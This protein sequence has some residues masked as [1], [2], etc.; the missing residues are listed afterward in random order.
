MSGPLEAMLDRVTAV[1]G[2]RGALLAARQDGLVV[3]QALMEGVDGDAI[4][5]L[6]ASLFARAGQACAETGQGE[7]SLV[8]CEGADGGL[9]V[10]PLPDG[11]LLLVALVDPAGD[12][13]LARLALLAAGRSGD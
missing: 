12:V 1:Q 7:P 2:V 6:A 4:A 9:L 3:T 8:H 13:G 5:A 10:A 11:E